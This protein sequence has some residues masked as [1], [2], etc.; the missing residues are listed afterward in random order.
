MLLPAHSIRRSRES[1]GSMV[2][3]QREDET[4]TQTMRHNE[5]RMEY[6]NDENTLEK[7]QSSTHFYPPLTLTR[8]KL[9]AQETTCRWLYEYLQYS[10]PCLCCVKVFNTS[11]RSKSNIVIVLS[12]EEIIK[13]SRKFKFSSLASPSS[14]RFISSEVDRGTNV[15]EVILSECITVL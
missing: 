15:I 14:L 5:L 1:K 11:N 6:D 3:R 8:M 9:P 4:I 2:Y 12:R 7:C 13:K 10:T